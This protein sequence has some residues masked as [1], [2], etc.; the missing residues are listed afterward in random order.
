MTATAVASILDVPNAAPAPKAVRTLADT[1]L[2]ANQ[3]EQLLV[4]MLYG[5]ELSGHDLSSRL[6]LPYTILEPIIEHVRAEL[7]LEVRGSAGSGTAGFRYALTDVGRDRARQ[8]LDV[9]QYIGP[10]PVPLAAYVEELRALAAVRGYIDRERLRRGFSNLI[11]KDHVLE[12]LGPAVN[13]GKAMFLYGPPGNGKT[14]IGEGMGRTIGGDMYVPHAIDID[15]QIITVFDP[16]NHEPLESETDG[17]SIVTIAA[18][19][20]ALG[21]YSASRGGRRRRAHARHARP[22]V[23]PDFEVLRSADSAEGERRRV[24]RGR[25]RPSADATRRSVEPLDRAAREPRR[26]SHAPHGQEDPDSVRRAHRLR[27]EP[28]SEVAGRRSIPSPYPV[29]DSDRRSV[30]RGVRADFRAELPAAPSAVPQGDGRVSGAVPLPAEEPPVP[31]VPAARPARSGHRAVPVPRHRAGDYARA[32]RCGLRVVFPGRRSARRHRPDDD[33]SASPTHARLHGSRAR[34]CALRADVVQPAGELPADR[35]RDGPAAPRQRVARARLHGAAASGA[36]GRSIDGGARDDHR[37][38]GRSAAFFGL[39]RFPASR[40]MCSQPSSR[41]SDCASSSR[42]SWRS[43][44]ASAWCR[45]IAAWSSK[46]RTL[47][48]GI[49]FISGTSLRTPHFWLRNPEPLNLAIVLIADSA[50]IVRALIEER[51][52]RLDAAYEAYCQRVGWHLV[53]GVF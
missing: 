12:Q 7:Q 16:I 30:A 5:G 43:G 27:D 42:A 24:P 44:A 2:Y 6:C 53:P 51:V 39:A 52:L 9:N 1:G 28:R 11:I 8:Y 4:K 33:I 13:A 29:Q 32:A 49:R 40:P 14:V 3:I 36:A 37:F 47:S 18:A 38:A 22:H 19:R 26:L 48:C 34:R 23:Q 17:S 25:L 21:P 41:P 50:L 31:R 46:V 35:P 15:G 45:P 10:A 20:S